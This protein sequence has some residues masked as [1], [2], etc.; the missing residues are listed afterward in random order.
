MQV[1]HTK[2][3]HE[4]HSL[5]VVWEVQRGRM[6]PW[7]RNAGQKNERQPVQTGTAGEGA[8][9]VLLGVSWQTEAGDEDR[10]VTVEAEPADG[11]RP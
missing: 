1:P 9:A 6:S 7:V 3:V 8:V 4:A 5:T 2:V 10:D 11:G